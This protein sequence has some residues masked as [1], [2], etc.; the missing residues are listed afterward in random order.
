M[1]LKV[2]SVLNVKL[3]YQPV[4]KNYKI[5]G[6]IVTGELDGKHENYLELKAFKEIRI[7]SGIEL[8][9][10]KQEFNGKIS[11]KILSE[12]INTTNITQRN[13]CIK[14]NYTELEYD[15][16]FKK[17]WRFFRPKV[18]N[19][20]NE[21]QRMDILNRMISTYIIS[22][23][24]IGIKIENLEN[25]NEIEFEKRSESYISNPLKEAV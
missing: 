1:K 24:S 13:N 12:K 7:E 8:S 11:F 15:A 3:P 10:E 19:I 25:E 23:V 16:L 6:W 20:V 5:Y 21:Y 18:S 22:A 4:N 2:L 17:A 14:Q 9:V